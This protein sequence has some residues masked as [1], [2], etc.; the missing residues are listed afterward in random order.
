[1]PFTEYTDEEVIARAKAHGNRV[2]NGADDDIDSGI[3][4]AMNDRKKREEEIA[5][6]SE[7]PP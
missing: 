5:L 7:T 3:R 2:G 6:E 1:M 4:A